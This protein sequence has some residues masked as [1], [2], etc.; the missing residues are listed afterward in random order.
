MKRFYIL[1]LILFMVSNCKKNQNIDNSLLFFFSYFLQNVE[2]NNEGITINEN[3]EGVSQK[4]PFVQGSSVTITELNDDLT[5]T[6]KVYETQTK[7]DLGNFEFNEKFSKRYI[8]IEATGKYFNEVKNQ[9]TTESIALSSIVD[10]ATTKVVNVNI[11]TTL[12]QKRLKGLVEKGE[13]FHSAKEKSKK[14]VMEIFSVDTSKITKPL[15]ELDLRTEGELL[16][17]SAIVQGQ[18]GTTDVKKLID[19]MQDDLVSSGRVDVATKQKLVAQ[20]QKLKE[21]G[22]FDKIKK[23]LEKKFNITIPIDIQKLDQKE[24][25]IYNRISAGKNFSLALDEDGYLYAWG[26]NDAGQLGDGTTTDSLV[27]KKIGSRKYKAVAAGYYHS[28]AID[29]E[30][31]LYA[32]GRNGNGQLG[33][34]TETN[35]SV[36]KKIGDRKYKVII[37]S[38]EASLALD[39]EGYLYTWGSRY[40]PVNAKGIS[41]APGYLEP[42]KRGNKKYKT[43]SSN[44]SQAFAIDEEDYLW[45]WGNNGSGQLGDGTALD[46]SNP[47]KIG[48][49][50]YLSIGAGEYHTVAVG[51]DGYLYTWGDW[52]GGSDSDSGKV[53]PR[54]FSSVRKYK[55]VQAGRYYSIALGEDG[56]LYSWSGTGWG[57]DYTLGLGNEAVVINPTKIGNKKYSAVNAGYQHVLALDEQGNIYTWGNNSSNTLGIGAVRSTNNLVKIGDKKYKAIS[58]GFSSSLALDKEGYLYA[59]GTNIKGQ[60]G[61]GT[62]IIKTAPIKIGNKKY[63]SIS[64]TYKTSLAIDENDDLY[65]WGVNDAGQL[66][67]NTTTDSLVPKKIGSR[68]YKAVAAGRSHSLAIDQSDDLYAWGDNDYGQLGDNTTTDSLVP[69]KIGTRKYKSISTRYS[70]S[71]AIGKNDEL[72]YTWGRFY[73]HYYNNVFTYTALGIASDAGGVHTKSNYKYLDVITKVSDTAYKSISVGYFANSIALAKDGSL[74][75]WGL[76]ENL[77]LGYGGEK[78]AD[79]TFFNQVTPRKVGS[80]VFTHISTFDDESLAIDD[81]GF[82]WTWGGAAKK[83][84]TKVNDKTWTNISQGQ[85]FSLALDTEGYLWAWG[86][87][88]KGQLGLGKPVG[89]VPIQIKLPK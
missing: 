20:E 40:Q 22:G 60:L 49:N 44:D 37:G 47:V 62:K 36:P 4:G 88:D 34:G 45:A 12:Q 54:K 25:V 61:D 50:K 18:G 43:I 67:D 65:A 83:S 28:L 2:K 87:N 72:L 21:T 66:G 13:K 30:G 39:A 64:I 59:W 51:T 11:L 80:Q 75:T 79:G 29:A 8:L 16:R 35:R 31:Y 38:E 82:L 5:K 7:D 10:I 57:N 17:A 48:D 46:R 69:K 53:R 27:P 41:P 19:S 84:L 78:N 70:R 23:N 73:R 32:W 15:N 68:K 85:K 3:L 1:F 52:R 42:T 74:Y 77:A 14:E 71:L 56:Y 63:K 81:S 86:N 9:T 89:W 76:N 26:V 6:S 24:I 33:D 58:A 55:K